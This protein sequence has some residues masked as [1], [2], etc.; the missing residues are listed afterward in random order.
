MRTASIGILS[1]LLGALAGCQRESAPLAQEAQQRPTPGLHQSDRGSP[2]RSLPAQVAKAEPD[3]TAPVAKSRLRTDL[4][5]FGV[6]SPGSEL[7]HRYT[8]TNDSTTT[9]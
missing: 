3:S 5:D 2:D 4:W 8:I 9:W 1:A 7:H 6:V